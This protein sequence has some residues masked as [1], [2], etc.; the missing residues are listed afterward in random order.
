MKKIIVIIVLI[1][2]AGQLAY[3]F[4]VQAQVTSQIPRVTV[5]F[6]TPVILVPRGAPLT[7]LTPGTPVI[8]IPQGPIIVVPPKPPNIEERSEI[9]CDV[10]EIKCAEINCSPIPKR[11]SSYRACIKAECKTEEENCI[12]Y[13]VKHL[14]DHAHSQRKAKSKN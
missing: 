3:P 7:Q 14:R 2:I 1:I 13:L 5:P 9:D 8:T 11:Y 10:R 6:N 12:I 4:Q